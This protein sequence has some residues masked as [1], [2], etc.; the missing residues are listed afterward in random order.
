VTLA[1]MT[2]VVVVVTVAPVR[3]SEFVPTPPVPLNVPLTQPAPRLAAVEKVM[4]VGNV[5]LMATPVCETVLPLGLVIVIVI[6]EVPPMA[7]P[8]EPKALV[9]VGGVTTFRTAVAA[10]PEPS[11][12]AT[13]PVELVLLPT[14]ELVTLTDI[15]QLL[16]PGV[17]MEPPERTS[18][19]L[20]TVGVPP[21]VFDRLLGDAV[22]MP[23]G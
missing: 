16:G 1:L 5:S 13:A 21:Q 11:L 17:P 12:E 14:V 4:P 6:V 8:A 22:V 2:H 18:D 19:P 23:V 20:L 9:T 3:L 15:V 10:V 7:M